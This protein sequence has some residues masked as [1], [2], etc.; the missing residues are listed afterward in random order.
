MFNSLLYLTI[1]SVTVTVILGYSR[2]MVYRPNAQVYNYTT[3]P[4]E[5]S[6]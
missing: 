1:A 3:S 6:Y 5:N 2:N 4:D